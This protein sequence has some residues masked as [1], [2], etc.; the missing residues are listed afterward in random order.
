[1]EV[2]RILAPAG[3]KGLASFDLNTSLSAT[4]K[5]TEVTATGAAGTAYLCHPFLAHAAQINSGFQP[6]F[7]AQPPLQSLKPFNADKKTSCYVLIE[8][9]IGTLKKSDVGTA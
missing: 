5:C 3:E 4:A 1:M 2:A 7:M 8:R 6:R 9:A